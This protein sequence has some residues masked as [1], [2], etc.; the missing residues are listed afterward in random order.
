MKQ[1]MLLLTLLFLYSSSSNLRAQTPETDSLE[2]Q[3]KSHRRKDTSKVNLLNTA[4][5]EF[6]MIRNKQLIELK[7]DKMPIGIYEGKRRTFSN[8]EMQL[9]KDDCLYLS[10][11]GYADQ[12]GGPKRK[13][14]KSKYLKELLLN[15]HDKEMREQHRILDT[16]IEEWRG[17]IEQTD[18]ILLMGIRI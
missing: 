15:I 18:D 9:K 14:Y 7:A 12:M 13:S 11:D 4:A 8:Q 10:T 6:Y 3:V 1:M 16:T 5:L 2:N 17:E